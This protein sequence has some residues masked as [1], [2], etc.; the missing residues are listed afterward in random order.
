MCCGLAES[1]VGELAHHAAPERDS[2]FVVEELADFP[3]AVEAIEDQK[4][5]FATDTE[6][7]LAGFDEE[8][9]KSKVDRRAVLSWWTAHE[10]EADGTVVL[11]DDQ[12]MRTVISE[13]ARHQFGFA[14]AEFASG[15][16]D[17]RVHAEL[18]QVVEILSVASLNPAT[19]LR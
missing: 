10:R 5:G 13:P 12:W 14:L 11:Q 16:E 18:R 19:V 2:R 4:C 8:L 9:G 15:R 7:A 6:S 1:T 3:R 17:A